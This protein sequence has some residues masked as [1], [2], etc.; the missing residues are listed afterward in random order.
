MEKLLF[1]GALGGLRRE[2]LPSG[3]R[4][5]LYATSLVFFSLFFRSSSAGS[6]GSAVRW[7]VMG[8]GLGSVYVGGVR[9]VR[10]VG[11][12]S[13]VLTGTIDGVISCVRSG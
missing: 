5:E 13:L 2:I 9:L 7:V 3:G 4:G 6:A 11:R 8:P 1:G 12:R 10:S